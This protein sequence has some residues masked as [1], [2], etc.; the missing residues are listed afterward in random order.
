M[1]HKVDFHK[2]VAGFEFSAVDLPWGCCWSAG[3][4]ILRQIDCGIFS[5]AAN[6]PKSASLS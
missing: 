2:S 3:L 5:L 1:Q 6:S 4:A